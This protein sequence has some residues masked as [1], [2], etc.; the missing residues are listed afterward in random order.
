MNHPKERQWLI[1]DRWIVTLKA[2]KTYA[3]GAD[4]EGFSD[5]IRLRLEELLTE[6]DDSRPIQ[7]GMAVEIRNW[8][9]NPKRRAS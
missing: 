3:D 6:I 8:T 4:T 9:D 7:G 1:V 2:H 5:I